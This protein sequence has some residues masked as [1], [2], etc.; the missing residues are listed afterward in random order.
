MP[1]ARKYTARFN[2]VW[3]PSAV[4]VNGAKT[5]A[6]SY[7]GNTLTLTVQIPEVPV[8]EALKVS[9][10]FSTPLKLISPY[11]RCLARLEKS[12]ELL[13]EQ[14]EKAKRAYPQD[15]Y[16]LQTAAITGERVSADL[17]RAVSEIQ[18]LPAALAESIKIMEAYTKPDPAVM[19]RILALLRTC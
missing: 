13:D 8:S 17:S 11:T 16:P 15:F 3:P 12:K 10:D 9:V 2:G 14:W 18:N 7:D 5:S 19:K 1:T 6:W 4:T